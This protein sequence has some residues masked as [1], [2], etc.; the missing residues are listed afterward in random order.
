[1]I[2]VVL[3]GIITALAAP[4]ISQGM[5]NTSVSDA[6]ADIVVAFRAARTMSAQQSKA[7]RVYVDTR[8][9]QIVRVDRGNDNNCDSLPAGCTSDPAASYGGAHCGLRAAYIKE[10]RYQR[11]GV[12]IKGIEI[13]T[14]AV[15]NVSLCITP[16]GRVYTEAADGTT[17]RLLRPVEILVDRTET[18]GGRS[19]GV[20]RRVIVNTMGISRVML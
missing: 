17:S 2:V 10:A 12:R 3:I 14:K 20:V 18:D 6:T 13:A 8:D 7:H 19:V 9:P 5:A 16:G 15:N 11:R 4:Q 1:M